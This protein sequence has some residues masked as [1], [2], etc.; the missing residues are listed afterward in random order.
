MK[1][2]I[3][4]Y[5]LIFSTVTIA[6]VHQVKMLN[7]NAAGEKMVFEPAFLHIKSGDTV[8]F[9]PTSKGHQ[10]QSMKG[11]LPEGVEKFKS[12]MNKEFSITLEKSGV[13][14]I[15]C[16]PH[17][18]MGMVGMIVVDKPSNLSQIKEMK[19]RGKKAKARMALLIEQTENLLSTK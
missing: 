1:N 12:K 17:Y 18:A 10:V 11:G 8:N 15:N 3:L 5:L 14:A 9:L 13:Y 19:V 2:I 4:F 6:E 7:K 16:R